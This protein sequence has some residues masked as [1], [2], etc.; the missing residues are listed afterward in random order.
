[1]I[2]KSFVELALGSHRAEP[3]PWTIKNE[4]TFNYLSLANRNQI[5]AKNKKK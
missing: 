1:M 4:G 2:V 3:R 5:V